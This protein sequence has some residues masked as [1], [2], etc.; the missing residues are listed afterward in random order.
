[1]NYVNIFRH[2]SQAENR[3]TNGLISL[4]K[5]G[6]KIDKDTLNEFGLLADISLSKKM[7]FRVLREFEGTADAEIFDNDSIMLI[8]TKIHSGTLR[9]EQIK[10]HLKILDRYNQ[11]NKRLILLTPDS[12]NSYYISQFIKISPK[13]IVHI[14]WDSI[15][16]LLQ[17]SQSKDII[18]SDLVNDYIDE[19]KEDIFEQDG[20]GKKLILYDRYKGLVLEVE[21][22]KVRRDPK[23]KTNS[24]Y[25]WSNKFVKNTLRIYHKPIPI[26]TILKIPPTK[27][28]INKSKNDGKRHGF[29]N[30]KSNQTPNW[31]LTREQ[32][33]WLMIKNEK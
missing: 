17:K 18:F 8:E 22:E 1:M 21:I 9:G 33:E 15:I 23:R 32:Y 7:D 10:R 3:Y 29:C 20:K 4:L 24:P 5:I 6:S 27:K 30:F 28:D 13:K 25:P 2:Y 26:S 14:T 16:N 11:K 12:A 19:I 31:N